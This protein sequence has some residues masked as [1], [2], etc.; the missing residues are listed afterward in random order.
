MLGTVNLKLLYKY[1]S[2]YWTR[3]QLRVPTNSG[4]RLPTNTAVGP[5]CMATCSTC[6]VRLHTD[7]E[8]MGGVRGNRKPHSKF[9]NLG[10]NMGIF[11]GGGYFVFKKKIHVHNV[12][13]FQKM[14]T[15]ETQMTTISCVH[16]TWTGMHE[17]RHVHQ[18]LGRCILPSNAC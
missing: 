15:C 7:S 14:F 5:T 13:Q 3:S 2:R 1:T 8:S 16:Q 9:I 10:E 18:G 11:C 12:I 6:I 17:F 4:K